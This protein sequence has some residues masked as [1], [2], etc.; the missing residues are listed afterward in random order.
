MDLSGNWWTRTWRRLAVV[1][2]LL[3]LA[4]RDLR[5][6]RIARAKARYI[7]CTHLVPFSFHA[8]FGLACIYIRERDWLRARRELVLAR[9][10]APRRYRV[11]ESRIPDLTTAGDPAPQPDPGGGR[12][13]AAARA[14]GSSTVVLGDCATFE[15]W[16]R[17]QGLGPIR[18]EEIRDLDWDRLLGAPD[19]A[20]DGDR[21]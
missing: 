13:V 5:R 15:E 14:V 11:F 7:R 1:P 10:I 18:A 8:H 2:V 6:G 16:K 4:R 3:L 17:F 9:E 20:P 12:R 21:S 19:G